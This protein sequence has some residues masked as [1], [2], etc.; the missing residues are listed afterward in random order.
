MPAPTVFFSSP[1]VL[2]ASHFALTRRLF[3]TVRE[4]PEQ[5]RSLLPFFLTAVELGHCTT[6][7]GLSYTYTERHTSLGVG[8]NLAEKLKVE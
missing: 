4:A 2:S 8:S 5:A 3:Q 6:P 1:A 7:E